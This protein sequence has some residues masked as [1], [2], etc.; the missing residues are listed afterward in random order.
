[1]SVGRRVLGE[2]GVGSDAEE[3][4]RILLADPGMRESELLD[5]TTI[6]PT[7]LRSAL[8][9]LEE[10]AMVT[11]LSGSPIRLQPAPPEIVIDALISSRE[12]ELR[13]VRLD[14]RELGTL[15][16]L[17]PD[18]MKVNEIVEI[19]TTRDGVAQRWTQI[20]TATK[21]RLDVFVRPPIAQGS[22]DDGE[23]LQAQRLDQGVAVRGLYDREI[24]ARPGMLDHVWRMV[25]AGEKARVITELPMKLAISDCR[26][27]LVALV[28]DD[29]ESAVDAGLV[30]HRSALLDALIALF[31]SYWEHGIDIRPGVVPV[32]TPD[33]TAA[34]DEVVALMLSGF[35]DEAIARQLGVSLPTVRRRVK[36]VQRKLGVTT[37]VQ[38]GFALGRQTRA[39]TSD[40]D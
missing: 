27:A 11:R 39:A 22:P 29:S 26:A 33:G 10:L 16:R 32:S 17:H 25:T 4:Y 24:L 5:H 31:D 18:Q 34:E 9:Q 23:D 3:V 36:A 19:L 8:A 13:K 14:A 21:Q 6:G 37:R 28:Q 40:E 20:Q 35:K 15:R 38:A 7:R 1:M 2:V 12:E 30:V